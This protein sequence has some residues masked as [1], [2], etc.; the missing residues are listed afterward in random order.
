[1]G[2]DF[3]IAFFAVPVERLEDVM[4]DFEGA[5]AH[6]DRMDWSTD[7]CVVDEFEDLADKAAPDWN[8]AFNNALRPH[9]KELVEEMRKIERYRDVGVI[10]HRKEVLFVSGGLSWGD[11]PTKSFTAFNQL[12]ITGLDQVLIAKHH[13]K[14]KARWR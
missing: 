5:L 6:V 4:L 12:I 13:G 10:Y 8:E 9:L 1:M 11:P 7:E 2:A 3:L 14:R